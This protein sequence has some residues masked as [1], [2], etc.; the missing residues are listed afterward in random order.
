MKSCPRFTF[1]SVGT[2]IKYVLFVSLFLHLFCL[3]YWFLVEADSNHCTHMAIYKKNP[4]FMWKRAF[5]WLSSYCTR[6]CLCLGFFMSFSF[7]CIF[8]HS[9]SLKFCFPFVC[10]NLCLLNNVCF[11]LFCWRNKHCSLSIKRSS[12]LTEID[13]LKGKS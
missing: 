13:T 12:A 1:L 6:L 2:K 9:Y 10:F 4:K 11:V 7:I 3:F 5:V 8:M